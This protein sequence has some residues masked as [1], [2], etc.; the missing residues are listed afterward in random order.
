MSLNA[1]QA[2]D[3]LVAVI[4][5]VYVLSSVSKVSRKDKAAACYQEQ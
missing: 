4:V 3:S 5:P 1:V 2:V